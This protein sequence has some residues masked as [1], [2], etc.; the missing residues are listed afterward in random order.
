MS[1]DSL[2]TSS[3]QRQLSARE[4]PGAVTPDEYAMAPCRERQGSLRNTHCVNK[5]V[6]EPQKLER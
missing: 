6:S 1:S 3:A 2:D 5:S 4:S